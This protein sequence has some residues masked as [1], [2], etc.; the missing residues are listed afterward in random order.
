MIVGFGVSRALAA[1]RH[2]DL[3]PERGRMLDH[4][5][6]DPWDKWLAPA[7]AFGGSL[8]IPLVA[9]LDARFGRPG[10][11]DLPAR[12]AA[13]LLIVAGYVLGSYAMIENRYFSGVVRLQTERGHRVV[14]SRPYR[15]IR[16]PGYTGTLVAYAATPVLLGSPLAFMPAV[17]TTTVLFV[18]TALEDRTLQEKLPGYREYALRVRYRLLPGVW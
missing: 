5:N 12:L 10:G 14:S 6:A 9:G 3:L 8:F 11:F 18:R 16:H 2:S 4:E 7:L 13:G 15:W 17:L 1:R